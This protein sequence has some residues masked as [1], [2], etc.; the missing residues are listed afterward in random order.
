MT[1]QGS[2]TASVS[3]SR[4]G[5]TCRCPRCG[6]GRLFS[7]F[8]SLAPRCERCGL[9]FSFI[10]SGDGPAVFII[11]IAGFIVVLCALV[12]EV[13]YQPPYWLHA[14]L[15]IPLILV[16][17]LVPLRPTKALLIALQYHHKAAPAELIR[18]DGSGDPE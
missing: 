7:G 3:P 9:D 1:P 11:L 14:A 16:V 17:T 4:A 12:V 10:D 8:L 13:V 18:R 2:P 6:E 15:W 5:L